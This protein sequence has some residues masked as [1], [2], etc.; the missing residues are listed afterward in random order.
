MRSAAAEKPPTDAEQ[1]EALRRTLEDPVLFDR[2]LLGGDP[3]PVQESIL[4]AIAVE[5]ARVA[6]KACHAS[7]KTHGA[8]RAALWFLTRYPDGIV[9][10]TAPTWPQ[11]EKLLWGEIRAAVR[12]ARIRYPDPL[13]TELKLS[14]GNYALGLSTNEGIRFQG[15]HAPHVLMILD[16][17]P[18]VRPDIWEAIEGVRA[19]GDVRVLAIGNPTIIGGPF[20]DAF[21]RER[22]SWTVR[23]ISAFDTPNLAGIA[24]EDLKTWDREDARLFQNV[25]P[26]LTTRTWVREKWDD[27]GRHGHPMW[28]AR[29]V[30]NF[31]AQAEDALIWLT[32]I[33]AARVRELDSAV[34]K[35]TA[36][37]D[38]AGPG[39]DETVLTIRQGRRVLEEHPWPEK[40]PRGKILARLRDAGGPEAFDLVTVDS[41]G[42][43]YYL[44]LHIQD[45]GY[46]VQ[47]CNVGEASTDAERFKNLKAEL[48]WGLR[49]RFEDGDVDAR[50]V[51]ERTAEQLAT[52]KWSSNAR[53]QT[54]IMT[55]EKMRD[56]GI[57]S[58][59]RAEALM[60]AFAKPLLP[61]AGLA[62]FLAQEAA[63]K[64][65][66]QERRT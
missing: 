28:D 9:I 63:A 51:S 53:G 46:R 1:R 64:A 34:P 50:A 49:M 47:F 39:E 66:Q 29:V 6:V 20:Y 41:A 23:T 12:G 2:H 7:G 42:I 3:W 56:E 16:E 18:G 19:G 21:T 43:G 14:D 11:V 60:L 25:R 38:V 54:E 17:A 26:Y 27:W 59:D 52:L 8:A 44:A 5:R 62:E 24:L 15:F 31:P 35:K 33:E 13:T 10:T 57:P 30:A 32:W 61:G 55:K 40:D 36:G 65:A 58:P 22:S 45:A 37:I 4:R 48:Y